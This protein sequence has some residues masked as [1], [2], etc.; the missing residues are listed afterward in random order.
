[1]HKPRPGGLEDE[2][3]MYRWYIEHVKADCDSTACDF[4]QRALERPWA[5][6]CKQAAL[7]ELED[8]V[9]SEFEV[10]LAELERKRSAANE[11]ASGVI[12][13]DDAGNT[14]VA[15]AELES[16]KSAANEEASGF[17]VGDDV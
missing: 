8:G 10:A 16:E 9:V 12:V 3:T 17:I 11:E 4:C 14:Q 15:L 1:M 5:A 7:A 2:V 6:L 13:G